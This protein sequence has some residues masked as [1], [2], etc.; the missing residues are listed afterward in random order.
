[1]T[2]VVFSFM[3]G[4]FHQ[5]Y[6]VALAPYLAALVGMGV[7]VLW[8]ERGRWWARGALAGTVAVTALWSYVL[9]GRTPDYLPWLRWAVL[10]GGLAGAAALLLAA[11]PGRRLSLA[12]VV[13]SFVVSLAGPAAYTLSTLNT[14][15]RG[16]IVTA[17]PSGADSMGG[18][19]G[20]LRGGMRPPGQNGQQ[21]GGMGQPPT[22]GQGSNQQNGMP[23][24]AMP[25]TAQGNTPGNAPGTAPG[26]MTEG[27]FPGGF[28]RGGDGGGNGGGGMGGLL[29]GSSVGTEARK[30]LEKNA[31]DYTWAAAAVGSQNAA[32]YQLATGD[33][34]MAIGGFNGSD[35]SPTLSQFK[36]YVEDGRIH[37]FIAGGMGGGGGNSGTSSQISSW[38]E[39]NFEKVTAGSATFYDLTRPKSS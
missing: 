16:S 11:R 12:A 14:G 27:G 31:G 36:K 9:L 5:Y 32:S 35:P 22:G 13:L 25:G 33:P 8:E 17:G 3:A 23:P 26:G 24:G 19:G 38:V 4:I 34:V 20:G 28:P 21:G 10:I 1:M 29:N 15:H 6:T 18:R 37:Y 7:T 2:A 39:D 30:L